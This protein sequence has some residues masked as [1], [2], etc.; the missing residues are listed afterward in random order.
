[1]EY[2]TALLRGDMDAAAEIPKSLPKDQLNKAAQFLK[3]RDLKEL[4]L[5]VTTDP[6]HKFDLSLQLDDLDS[7]VDIVRTIPETE[8]ETK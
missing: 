6:A 2:Q 3:G 7:A 1:M 5:Q 8:A 4:A